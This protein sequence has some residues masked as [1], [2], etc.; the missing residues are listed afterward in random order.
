MQELAA[1]DASSSS[2]ISSASARALL[3]A[4]LDSLHHEDSPGSQAITLRHFAAVHA[5]AGL[6][7]PAADGSSTPPAAGALSTLR[8][9]MRAEYRMAVRRVAAPDFLEGVRSLLVDKDKCPKW[10]PKGLSGIDPSEAA[11]LA[12]ALPASCGVAGLDLGV[13]DVAVAAVA[14]R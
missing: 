2:S 6:A 5:A 10:Q 13:V 7:N 12:E 1:L 14:S 8:G 3:R 9:V 4:A 11:R